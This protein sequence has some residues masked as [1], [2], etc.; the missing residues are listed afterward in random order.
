[1]CFIPSFL[2]VIF[3]NL[4][5]VL[6]KPQRSF[7]SQ[8]LFKFWLRVFH[9]QYALPSLWTQHRD[10]IYL[11]RLVMLII[12]LS[13]FSLWIGHLLSVVNGFLDISNLSKVRAF[14]YSLIW[15]LS[16]MKIWWLLALELSNTINY[17]LRFWRPNAFLKIRLSFIVPLSLIFRFFIIINHLK[18]CLVRE[19][20]VIS[21]MILHL[22]LT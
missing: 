11:S 16:R 4:C 21:L 19:D 15:A 10:S 18:F 22:F 1:M 9:L 6:F 5:R 3:I 2:R 7:G 14:L 12:L 20:W 17:V 13:D 8:R